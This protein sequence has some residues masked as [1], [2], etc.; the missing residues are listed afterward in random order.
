MA[1][2]DIQSSIE[3][4]GSNFFDF[5]AAG[6]LNVTVLVTTTDLISSDASNDRIVEIG[7]PHATVP[8]FLAFNQNAVQDKGAMVPPISSRRYSVPSGKNIKAITAVETI[9]S[10]QL[11]TRPA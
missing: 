6:P 10:I 8:L 2:S 1:K 9:A 7:N 11:W 5:V 4:D 3:R